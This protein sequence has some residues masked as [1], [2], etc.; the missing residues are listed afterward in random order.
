MRRVS[1][2]DKNNRI[3]PGQRRVGEVCFESGKVK[4]LFNIA[5]LIP[6]KYGRNI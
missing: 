5:E 6:M 4:K 3:A 2:Q 1:V